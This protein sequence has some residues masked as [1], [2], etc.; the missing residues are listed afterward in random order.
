MI[1]CVPRGLLDVICKG[2]L[3]ALQ[4]V[5]MLEIGKLYAMLPCRNLALLHLSLGRKLCTRAPVVINIDMRLV[6]RLVLYASFGFL[7]LPEESCTHLLIDKSTGCFNLYMW[8]NLERWTIAGSISEESKLKGNSEPSFDLFH[9]CF[10]S[11]PQLL[12]D[13]L[14]LSNTILKAMRVVAARIALLLLRTQTVR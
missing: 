3:R 11:V 1:P 4:S 5:L 12:R 14:Y 2:L 8:P 9:V 6:R 7:T 13:S 10:C